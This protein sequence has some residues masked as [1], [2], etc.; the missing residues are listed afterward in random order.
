M[1]E[2]YF[3]DCQ[4]TRKYMYINDMQLMI[5]LE[6]YSFYLLNSSIFHHFQVALI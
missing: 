5:Y 6:F 3:N 1:V 2:N 4:Q